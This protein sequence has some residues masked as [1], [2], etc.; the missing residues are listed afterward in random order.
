MNSDDPVD[1][2]TASTVTVLL[3]QWSEGD[4][5][6]LEHLLPLV[7]T[8]LRQIARGYMS[9]QHAGHTL[10]T[11]ALVNEAFL[12]MSDQSRKPFQNRSHFLAASAQA[13]RHLLIDHAR[14]RKADKRFDPSDRITMVEVPDSQV[15]VDVDVLSLEEALGRLREVNERQEQVV[16][17]RYFGGMTQEEIAEVLDV[18]VPTVARDW[19][20]ARMLLH[21]WLSEE[22][23][24]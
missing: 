5:Q 18:S 24:A 16:T 14:K 17:L 21:G 6:A 8:E 22:P 10:Q 7:Y 15:G 11:T 9:R 20:V 3:E 13:M 2:A 23:K 1:P 19:R 12:R 4:P